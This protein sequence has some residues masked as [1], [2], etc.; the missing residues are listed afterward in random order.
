ME[1]V[2]ERLD[3]L[4]RAGKRFLFEGAQAVMLD[5]DH[6]SYPQVSRS[7]HVGATA[8]CGSGMGPSAG[9]CGWGTH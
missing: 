7:N 6:G 2:W 9:G 3:E 5:V 1:P 4:R 8:Q